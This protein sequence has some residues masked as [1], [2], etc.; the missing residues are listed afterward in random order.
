[1]TDMAKAARKASPFWG[2]H[3]EY[4][5]LQTWLFEASLPVWNTVGRDDVSG[6]FFEKIDADLQPVEAPRRTR[7]VARQIYCFAAAARMGWTGAAREAVKHGAEFLTRNCFNSD[8]TVLMTV[9]VRTGERN[10]AFDLYDHAF[11]LFGLASAASVFPDQHGK[12]HDYA[13]RCVE[14]MKQG[15]AH[16]VFGFQ[17]AN[18]PTAPLRSNPHM[19][20]FE[21]FLAWAEA[22]DGD[23]KAYW[24]ALADEMGELCLSK[25]V[26]TETGAVREY[27]E[28]DWSVKQ[29][30]KAAPVEPGHQ[31]E[32]G[33]LLGRWGRLALRKDAL[34][35]AKRLVEIGEGAGIASETCLAINGLNHDLTVSDGAY[36]LWPQTERIKA[37]VMMAELAVGRSDREYALDKVAEAARGLNVF[38]SEV[39]SGIWRD[40]LTQT[41]ETVREPA[42]AS[43]LYHIT[44]A[45]E[46]MHRY[47]Y[48]SAE[49]RPALF[50]DRDGVII[51]DSGYVGDFRGVRLLEGVADVVKTFRARG[52][53]VFVVTNQSGIGRGYYDEFDYNLVRAKISFML[54]EQGAILDDERASP[55][56]RDAEDARYLKGGD[57]RKPGSGMI[58]SILDEWNIDMKKSYLVGD[59]ESDIKAANDAGILGILFDGGNIEEAVALAS[60]AINSSTQDRAM[61]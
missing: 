8:G 26:S 57:W 23:A 17:E 34:V 48:R 15:W 11:A 55:Y 61:S 53:Y 13:K 7:V 18:P 36:R 49:P 37:W 35:A 32:W 38:L 60:D 1:M 50:L 12:M 19:H 20:L 6:G 52:G 28:L 31:F 29:D 16:P 40:R 42:P 4:A 59:K 10:V 27:F 39:P 5:K 9:D 21:A 54:G 30:E 3:S 51:E 45:I 33:W 22:T 14:A 25:F 47:L 2:A 58:S 41:M 43:S 46:E 56:F 44:C 24:M